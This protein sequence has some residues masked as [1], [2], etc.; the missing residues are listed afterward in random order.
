MAEPKEKAAKRLLPPRELALFCTQVSLFLQAGVNLVEGL[1]L[2]QEDIESKALREAL[3]IVS[4]QVEDRQS[5]AD[6]MK[7]VGCFP[8]YLIR[9]ANIGETSGTLDRTMDAMA[10]SYEREQALKERIKSAVTY[11]LLLIVMMMAVVFLLIVQVLPMFDQLLRSLGAEMPG[12]VQGLM[13]FGQFVGNNALIIL[14]VLVILF[15]LFRLYA[16]SV[17]G[18]ETLDRLKAN[19]IFTK[20]TYRKIAAERFSTSMSFL[21]KANVDMEISLG[22]VRDVIGNRYMGEKIDNCLDRMTNGASAYDAIYEAGIFPRLFTR[23]LGIGFK[24]GDLDGMMWRLAGI[25]EQQVDDALGKITGSIEPIFVA[26]LSI[27]VGI[28]LISV[29]L[30]LIRIMSSIG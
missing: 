8:D 24:T 27:M 9:M 26:I 18:R 16:K 15:V 3:V 23:M 11:P 22:L 1:N 5:F 10:N 29:M 2:L 14:G 30:P 12:F 28:I 4:Q 25:Y 19:S 17:S 13:H 21:L 20:N 7:A 6:A